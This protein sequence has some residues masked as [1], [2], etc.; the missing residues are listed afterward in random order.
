MKLKD[1]HVVYQKIQIQGQD[2]CNMEEQMLVL[3]VEVVVDAR[4]KNIV[5]M[6]LIVIGE[7]PRILYPVFVQQLIAMERGQT[8]HTHPAVK[9]PVVHPINLYV[10]MVTVIQKE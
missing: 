4:I 2:E 7:Y 10:L 5:R 8:I 3:I 1:Y 9:A 6:S